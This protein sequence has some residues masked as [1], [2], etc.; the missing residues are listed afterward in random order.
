M[1]DEIV[2]AAI[3]AW[4]MTI[5]RGLTG[6]I[7]QQVRFH[8]VE[9]VVF[10]QAIVPDPTEENKDQLGRMDIILEQTPSLVFSIHS[11]PKQGEFGE[12]WPPQAAIDEYAKPKII[13]PGS[14]Q[15]A[16]LIKNGNERLKA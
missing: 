16:S 4:L 12:E 2:N 14:Q 9:D 15:A 10:L 13:I 6:L 5:I 7:P 3:E 8:Q 1:N 11:T